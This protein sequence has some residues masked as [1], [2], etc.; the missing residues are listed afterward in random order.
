MTRP[1]TEHI[2]TSLLPINSFNELT[3]LL[4]A[5]RDVKTSLSVIVQSN[6]VSF[7][8]RASSVLSCL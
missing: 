8:L 4:S 2:T 3:K 7:A 5:G 1:I 6:V